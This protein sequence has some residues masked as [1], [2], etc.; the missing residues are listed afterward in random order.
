MST[1]GASF[2]DGRYS[3]FSTGELHVRNVQMS[4]GLTNFRCVTKHTLTGE[5]KLSSYGRLI[6][7]DLKI[8]VAPKMTDF[9][10]SLVA[11]VGEDVE[12]P[13]AA[14]AYPSP[15]YA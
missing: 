3:I 9:K 1:Y 7:T 2:A 8:N 11:K 6:V 10:S 15:K 5:T 14:Q 4:D 13:C 12:L